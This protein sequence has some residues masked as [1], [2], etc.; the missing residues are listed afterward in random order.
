MF[1]GT[2]DGK[3]LM[4][5]AE[6]FVPS[7]NYSCWLPDLP[8]AVSDHLSGLRGLLYCGGVNEKEEKLSHCVTW[9]DGAWVRG[10]QLDRPKLRGFIWSRAEFSLVMGGCKYCGANTTLRVTTNS[11]EPSFD[12]RYNT[13]LACGVEDNRNSLLYLVGGH[14][15][16]PS[17]EDISRLTQIYGEEGYRG[18][19]TALLNTPRAGGHSC[20]GY[21]RED[22]LVSSAQTPVKIKHFLAVCR[23]S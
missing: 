1:G 14:K 3:R 9:R 16:R 15:R 4:K 20:S 5:S 19:L 11:S 18:D 23:F 17:W 2:P 22:N 7:T 10:P 21:W 12:L 13:M 6:L 8:E